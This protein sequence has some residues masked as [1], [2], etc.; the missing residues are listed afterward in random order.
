MTIYY[1]GHDATGDKLKRFDQPVAL[2]TGTLTQNG[3]FKHAIDKAKK[4]SNYPLVRVY[5]KIQP[6]IWN[7]RGLFELKDYDYLERDRRKVFEF[8]LTVTDQNIKIAE[9]HDSSKKHVD[10]EQTRQIPGRVKLEVYKRDKGECVKCGSKD[11][12]H[13]DH[14]LPYS[15]GGTS[16]K[17]ENIQLLCARHNLQKSNSL[18]K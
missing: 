16:L 2:P 12:I 17:T 11:N 10:L 13:F 4:D 1:E 9:Q 14:I 8:V 3:L 18:I 7:Y 5:E 6:G 15:L